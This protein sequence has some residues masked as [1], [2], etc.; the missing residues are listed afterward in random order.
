MQKLLATKKIFCI[1]LAM[2][3]LLSML[4]IAAGAAGSEPV[5]VPFR[6]LFTMPEPQSMR[7]LSV[8]SFG[9][10]FSLYAFRYQLPSTNYK[11]QVNRLVLNEYNVLEI[12]IELVDTG[13]IGAMVE[14]QR[15][16]VMYVPT[17]YTKGINGV[18]MK[19]GK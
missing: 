16:A 15:V 2:L 8:T 7:N 12:F 11:L 10:R 13:R 3:T 5:E 17:R 4:P 6:L 9:L 1:L 14:S 18:D 19:Y